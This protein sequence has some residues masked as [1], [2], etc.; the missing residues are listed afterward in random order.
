MLEQLTHNAVT[1]CRYNDAA[2]Y[3]WLLAREHLRRMGSVAQT[4]PGGA[5]AAAA[6]AKKEEHWRQFQELCESGPSNRPSRPAAGGGGGAWN[7]DYTR[8]PHTRRQCVWEPVPQVD[9]L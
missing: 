4:A 9:E 6:M 5:G 7:V 2:Y 3:F 1:E 8:V